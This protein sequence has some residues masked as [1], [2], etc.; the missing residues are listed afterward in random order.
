MADMLVASGIPAKVVVVVDNN[1]IDREV[2]A[3]KPTHVIIEALWVVPEKFE[4]LSKLHPGVKWIV[5]YH[6][7]VAFLASEGIAM[8]WTQGYLAQNNVFIGINSPRTM[9][10]FLP[11]PLFFQALCPTIL[12]RCTSPKRT[13][14]CS[15][16][17]HRP[18]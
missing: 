17:Q 9:V 12:P 3:Y 1:D 5:R 7:E 18:R 8:K 10:I 14:S 11:A 6:S 2:A 4:V 15:S 16:R 13:R